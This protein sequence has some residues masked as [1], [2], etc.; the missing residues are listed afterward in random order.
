MEKIY[1]LRSLNANDLFAMMRIINKIGINEVKKMFSSAEL[2][3]LLADTMKDGKVDDNAANAV[4]MQVMIELACLVT[5]HIPDCQNEIYDFMASLTGMKV[6]EIASLDMIV[7]VELVM[8]VFKKPEFKD[9]FQR[10]VGLL[11]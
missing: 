3:K 10:L 4:G 11:K 1:T 5:S 8:D 7:F 2:K 6:K 9:F